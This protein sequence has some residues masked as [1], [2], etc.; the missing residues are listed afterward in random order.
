[1]HTRP[2]LFYILSFIEG[3][4][5]MAAELLGAKMLA[6]YFGSSLYVWATVMAITLGGLAMGY[7]CGG[8]L[9]Y[10]KKGPLVLYYVMFLASVLVMLMPF[11]SKMILTLIGA[12]ALLPSVILSASIFLLPPIFMMGMV[13]PLIIR[14]I[15]T[16]I[17]HAGRS[18]G[19]I[20]AISTLGG[21]C[22]TF[23][24][25]FWII[26]SFGLMKP[27]IIT[28]II[29]GIIPVIMILKTNKAA[30]LFFLVFA[31][32]TFYRSFSVEFPAGLSVPYSS[33]GLLG[34][35][36][37]VDYPGKNPYGTTYGTNRVL[38]VNRITQ[39]QYNNEADSL[40]HFGY[41]DMI[42]QA[43]TL[44][45]EKPSV[46]VC[47]LGGG[48]LAQELLNK[49]CRVDACELDPRMEMV[50]K[51]Y[52]HLSPELAVHIDDARH[53]IRNT[54]NHYDAIVLDLFRGEESPGHCFSLEA[55]EE[56][57]AHLKPGGV[58]MINGNGFITGKRG[59]GMRAVY[60]TLSAGGLSVCLAA[61]NADEAWRNLLFFAGEKEDL[62][63]T[64]IA[65]MMKKS[66]R[67]VLGKESLS[68]SED[69]I[70]TD[71]LPALDELNADA[72]RNWRSATIT[73][74][75]SEA[76]RKRNLPIFQ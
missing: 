64:Q 28:G 19:A 42:L 41:V 23:L 25:G 75:V 59:A 44:F 31:S 37:V 49:G 65:E 57:K 55:I 50:A 4:A 12:H 63:L 62:K 14:S 70:L 35:V 76:Q 74:F 11:T 24:T 60:R 27:C 3:A 68:S 39:S 17:D 66:G 7:F 61:S 34:Q 67:P 22:S 20:Y 10:K 6:P 48:S 40:K 8:L 58:L 73:Y 18:A 53:Y 13:S 16:H 29:L 56:M 45:P 47:G 72:Y 54:T 38:F 32:W 69:L 43:V 33:E 36:M 30:A 2:Y 5:V 15:T 9:S 26:P 71:N 52:F 1:M 51:T 21:I 46:L